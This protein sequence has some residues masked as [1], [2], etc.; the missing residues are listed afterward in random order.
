MTQATR[1]STTAARPSARSIGEDSASLSTEPA[2]QHELGEDQAFDYI[3]GTTVVRVTEAENIRQQVARAVSEQYG[4]DPR[5]MA[6]DFL[7]LVTDP[8]GGRPSRRRVGIAVFEQGRP[9]EQEFIRRIVVTAARPKKNRA[10]STSSDQAQKH[11]TEVTALMDAA[12]PGCR[13]GM[14]TDGT[15]LLFLGRDS[16]G[17]SQN[18][19]LPL[20]NWPPVHAHTPG[21]HQ[22]DPFAVTAPSANEMMLRLAVRRCRNAIGDE[23]QSSDTAYWQL[24]YVLFAKLHHERLVREGRADAMSPAGTATSL[25]RDLFVDAKGS[26]SRGLFG[27]HDQL[28]LGDRALAFVLSELDPFDLHSTPPDTLRSAYQELFGTPLAGDRGQFFTPPSIVRLLVEITDPA[29][30]ETVIDP[31]CGSGGF[32]H[33]TIAHQGRSLSDPGGPTPDQKAAR[34]RQYARTRLFGADLDPVLARAAGVGVALLTGAPATTFHLDSLAYPGGSLPGALQARNHRERI[35]PGVVDVVLTNPPFGADIA[36]SG[37]VLE[38]FWTASDPTSTPSAAYQWTRQKD[39]TLKRGAPASS[40]APERLFVQK[41]IEWVRPGGRIGLVLPNGPLSNPGP[42]DE[43]LRRYILDECWVLASVEIPVE[44]FLVGAGVNIL[45]TALALR[46]KTASE[47][48]R[49][50]K[51]GPVDYPVFMAVVEKVGHDRRGNALYE[52]DAAGS[53]V[54]TRHEERDEIIACGE[55]I[56]RT[57]IRHSSVLDDD[58]AAPRGPHG[59]GR[60]Q[61]VITAYREFVDDHSSEFP[62][63]AGEQA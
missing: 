19:V 62:W 28:T 17:A 42:D 30:E 46:K 51:H 55:T 61:S 7:L 48:S 44:V 47:K 50:K 31:C 45:T 11:T 40:V 57:T 8:S 49:E 14:W 24:L 35:G 34:L 9:H 53:L 4:I 5:D 58:L 41:A 37:P 21:S 13:Y 54:L 22:D 36:V 12:G 39:G 52:R 25:L 38:E 16:S 43:A 26:A 59:A 15:D 27:Q 23:G 56:S 33:E 20:K 29:F 32:L 3:G 2:T 1:R 18:T 60:R 10:I 6:A 63:M